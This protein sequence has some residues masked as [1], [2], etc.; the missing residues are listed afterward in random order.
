MREE[1]GLLTPVTDGSQPRRQEMERLYARNG[2]AIMIVK[3]ALIES[4]TLYG[5]KISGYVMSREDSVDID[6]QADLAYAEFL[7]SRAR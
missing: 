1:N 7:L 3:R 4:G 2:P 6:E 5:K